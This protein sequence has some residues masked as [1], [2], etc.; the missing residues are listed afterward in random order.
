MNFTR[1][2]YGQ[3]ARKV[4]IT[5]NR[6]EKRNALDEETVVEL[7]NAFQVAARDASAKVILLKGAGPAFCAGADLEYL[8]RIAEQSLE[9]NRADSGKLATLFRSMYEVRKP[10]IAVVHGPALAGGCGLATVCDFILAGEMQSQ[11]GYTEARI[12]FV[13]AVVMTFLIRR[14][15]EGRARELTLGGHLLNA[16][17]AYDAGLVSAVVPDKGRN[18]TAEEL[19][20]RLCTEN[21]GT[22]MAFTKELIARLGGLNLL[23][24]LDF[25]SNMNA[26]ARM[27]PDC[28]Q[29]IDAFLQHK[30][31]TW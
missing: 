15:G 21:S 28:R 16:R 20:D 17:E 1:I 30:T 4:T 25:A 19:A 24:A 22:S 2:L 27:T 10:V 26:A 31:N 29:G 11:F 12:G 14:V 18:E 9:E 13:A 5:L 6:P 8:R 23:D 7:T 3:E